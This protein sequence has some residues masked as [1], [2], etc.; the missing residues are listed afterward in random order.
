M[1]RNGF[2]VID[3]VERAAA[4]LRGAMALEFGKSALIPQL[5]GEADHR[6]SLLLKERSD[7]GR[8][9]ASG[10]GDSNEAALGFG[11][12]GQ[13][14]ELGC[15]GHAQNQGTIVPLLSF[16]LASAIFR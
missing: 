1:L 6:A 14:V 15:R 8:V 5:H 13:G 2:G 11:A 3:V 9:D 16:Y 10:H 12:L 4:V 7:G